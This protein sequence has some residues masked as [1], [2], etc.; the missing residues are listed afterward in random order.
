MAD[1]C[2]VKDLLGGVTSASNYDVSPKNK[3]TF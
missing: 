3:D 1:F 2:A